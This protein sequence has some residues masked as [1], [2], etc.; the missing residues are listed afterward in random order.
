M[1]VEKRLLFG[2]RIGTM[3]RCAAVHA[4]HG[5]DLKLRSLTAEIGVGFLPIDLGLRRWRITL[6]DEDFLFRHPSCRLR[7][8]TYSRT[9][10]WPTG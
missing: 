7:K 2:T 4:A 3:K 10:D 8:L 9:R 1:S 6:R 5:K